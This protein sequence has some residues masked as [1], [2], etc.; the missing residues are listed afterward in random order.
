MRKD[1][2]SFYPARASVTAQP[3]ARA[4][5]LAKSQCEHKLVTLW[6]YWYSQNYSGCHPVDHLALR[7]R[8]HLYATGCAAVSLS[9]VL[10]PICEYSVKM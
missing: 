1:D 6:V 9:G 3:L 10:Q 4:F 5:L 2:S 7:R 8:L